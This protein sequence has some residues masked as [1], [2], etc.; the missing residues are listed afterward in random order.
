VNV[1]LSNPDVHTP[2]SAAGDE[3]SQVA[4][5]QS[6]SAL[7]ILGLLLGFAAPLALFGKLLLIVPLAGAGISLAALRRI[8][9][10]EGA[11]V[12]RS[13]AILGLIFSVAWGI[14]V[15]SHGAVTRQLREP[16]A[17]AAARH[18]I[19]LLLHGDARTAYQITYGGPPPDPDQAQDFGPEGN[20]FDR[21][22][23]MA[24]VE[25]LL[26]AGPDASIR[27]D[28][29]VRYGAQGDG[30]FYVRR[31]FTVTPRSTSGVEP[32]VHSQ[33]VGLLLQMHR[34]APLRTYL[35]SWQVMPIEEDN[36][37]TR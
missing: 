24:E 22:R 2:G 30:E 12:G 10:S 19:Q 5:Y 17:V 16:Q 31:R 15:V 26:G 32:G 20:P 37:A 13:I 4:G 6:L 25:A 9:V 34:T 8:A 35:K 28:G 7:A 23:K 3:A 36:A 11:L 27:D 18:W 33:P 1:N 29:T 14:G 21:F